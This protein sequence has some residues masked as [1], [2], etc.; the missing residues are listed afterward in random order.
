M[1]SLIRRLLFLEAERKRLE[2]A[3]LAYIQRLHQDAFRQLQQIPGMG[4]IT[5]ATLLA[6]IGDISRFPSA[7][8]LVAYAGL[9]PSVH[10]SGRYRGR[11]RLSKRGSPH[12]RRILFLIAQHLVRTTRRFATAY[13]HYRQ[14]GRSY[15]ETLVI[16]ARKILVVFYAL[17][18]RSVPFKDL[19]IP[20]SP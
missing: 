12:L 18:S 2:Q 9:D 11:S 1:Q 17:L 3:I 4:P 7:K 20:E 6:E 14:K 13:H 16:V 15:K 5:T 8:H 10:Q 19:P